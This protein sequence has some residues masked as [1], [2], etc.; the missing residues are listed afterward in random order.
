MNENAKKKKKKKSLGTV[1]ITQFVWVPRFLHYLQQ[2][3]LKLLLE[4]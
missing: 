3:D 4:N 2:C 1:S